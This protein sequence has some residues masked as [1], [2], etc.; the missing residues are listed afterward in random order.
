MLHYRLRHAFRL[1]LLSFVQPS[2][3]S[4]HAIAAGAAM[5]AGCPNSMTCLHLSNHLPTEV[6]R[7]C[8]L[9]VRSFHSG[10]SLYQEHFQGETPAGPSGA[11]AAKFVTAELL[12]KAGCSSA[13][14]CWLTAECSSDHNA[15]PIEE[16][17]DFPTA[18]AHASL[19]PVDVTVSILED[20]SPQMSSSLS[21][22]ASV[23]TTAPYTFF[24]CELPGVFSDN[25]LTLRPDQPKALTFTPTEGTQMPS[26]AKFLDSTR[27]YT[28]NNKQPQYLGKAAE[29]NRW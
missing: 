22:R 15:S 7:S 24:S 17:V 20:F 29:N 14:E 12:Q 9:H 3:V 25:S 21:F 2:N 10:H 11:I 18:L 27:I 23:N 26:T 16:A 19:R 13:E 8:I 5:N 28:M 6:S 4:P 1:L